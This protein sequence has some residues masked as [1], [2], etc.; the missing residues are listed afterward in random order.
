MSE[1]K[2]INKYYP[3]DFDPSKVSK[4]NKKVKKGFASMPTIRLMTP[5]S[6]ICLSCN[7]WISKSRKFN[8]RKETTSETY[9]G[10]KIVRLHIRCPKCA[11]EII[12]R[13]DPK[14]ADFV[15]ENG[16]KRAYDKEKKNQLLK[17]ES[18]EETM[19]RLEEEETQAREKELAKDKKR[20]SL[21]E[22]EK[23]L[24]DIKRQQDMNDEIDILHQKSTRINETLN[25][26][27]LRE[28]IKDRQRILYL[29][30]QRLQEEEDEKEA[31]EAFSGSTIKNFDRKESKT[32]INETHLEEYTESGP[33]VA[34]KTHLPINES[35]NPSQNS[36]STQDSNSTEESES[37]SDY[38]QPLNFSRPLQT[39]QKVVVKRKPNSLGI[40]VKRAKR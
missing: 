13:T 25:N 2:A 6:M 9:L 1:R 14:S 17:E 4:K 35:T 10:M 23:K 39:L 27:D 15:V 18:L 30:R 3:P 5:F 11:T 33:K 7:E 20:T 22:L 24:N 31:A 34:S 38:D 29:E 12:F 8:A 36:N 37:D 40:A 19:A 26:H 32:P 16:A 28:A 21:E